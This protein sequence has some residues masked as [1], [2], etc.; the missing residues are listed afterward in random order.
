MERGYRRIG[1]PVRLSAVHVKDFSISREI[2]FRIL[3]TFITGLRTL[4]VKVS[5]AWLV[6]H[7]ETER[8]I[9][10][11]KQETSVQ[12][13]MRRSMFSVKSIF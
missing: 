5:V 7:G 2:A 8:R 6:H 1:R 10:R 12:C 13:D 9:V 11:A 4:I 3:F